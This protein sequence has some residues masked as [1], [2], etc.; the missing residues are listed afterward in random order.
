MTYYNGNFD[1]STIG[2]LAKQ[3]VASEADV[4]VSVTTPA[5]GQL[6]GANR[7]L[8]PLIYTF[9][10]EPEALG[11]KG[12]GSLPNT[13]GLS[14]R[15]NY[16]R[17]LDLIRALLP[18]AKKIGFLLTASE[19]NAVTIHREFLQIAPKYGFEI[20][21][22]TIGQAT[23]IRTAAETLAPRVDLFL[24]GGDNTIASGFEALLIPA[25][26]RKL[27]VFACD[28]ESVTRGAIAAVSV[29]YKDMGKSTAE[30]CAAVLGDADP[31]RIPYKQYTAS[32]LILN[33]K[34]AR[35]LGLV[36]PDAIKYSADLILD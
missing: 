23:D 27:P 35:Y 20:I 1:L 11:Y 32:R 19:P 29:D 3:M 12:P 21:T 36:F 4:L 30:M 22:A 16:K 33:A 7:G 34:T 10:S 26:A 17:S 6:I 2:V 31:N 14:D 24:F 18:T 13:T 15:V 8:K 5:T 9:V 25:N 28:E